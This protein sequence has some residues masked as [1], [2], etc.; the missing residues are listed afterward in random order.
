MVR[1][2]NCVHRYSSYLDE[3]DRASD[4]C[5][6][7]TTEAAAQDFELK[8][9]LDVFTSNSHLDGRVQ[10]QAGTCN[11]DRRVRQPAIKAGSD[12]NRGNTICARS[13]HAQMTP[14]QLKA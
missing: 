3:L 6:K 1:G 2:L 11:W 10:P 12:L 9:R 7:A 5:G 13:L 8:A 4:G 14:Q